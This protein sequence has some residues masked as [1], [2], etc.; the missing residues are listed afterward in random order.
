[1]MGDKRQAEVCVL[2]GLHRIDKYTYEAIDSA[3]RQVGVIHNV[4][5]IANGSEAK[6][7]KN[8]LEYKYSDESL[9]RV[10]STPIPQLSYSLN[11]G[12]SL[13]DCEYVARMDADDVSEPDRL[14]KQLA[15]IKERRLD[16]L[17][18]DVRIIDPDGDVV[19]CRVYPKGDDINKLVRLKNPFCHPSVMY[20]KSFITMARGYNS[21]FSSEDYDLWL[22]LYRL[23]VK[24][25]N[26]DE[27]LIRYR[28]HS[29]S[30]Q[31]A[32]LAY[33]ECAGL[34]VREFLL[35]PNV[36]SVISILWNSFRSML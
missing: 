22:R 36:K 19:G 29:N 17:G 12:L 7:I 4:L 28:V 5:V 15:A 14:R 30:S 1:M 10:V 25:D 33:A 23:G 32:S 11:Y 3:I 21:G 2:I 24:W 13:T 9:L 20:R 35:K 18:S 27:K 16:V 31:G 6:K 26:L 34:A 8:E